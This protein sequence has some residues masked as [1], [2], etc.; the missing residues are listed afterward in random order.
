MKKLPYRE[1]DWFAVPLQD[2][3]Y[4]VGLVARCPRGGKVFL[5]YFFGPRRKRM[6]NLKDLQGLTAEDA[7]LSHQILPLALATNP[8]GY[9]ISLS[10]TAPLPLVWYRL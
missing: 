4:A 5:G 1:G 9:P 3:D 8:P 2:G 10:E 6:P 7:L